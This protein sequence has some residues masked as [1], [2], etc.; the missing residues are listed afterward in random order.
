MY[1]SRIDKWGLQ[2]H[3]RA[4]Q[5][6]A[7][8]HQKAERDAVQKTS[9]MYI[10]DNKVDPKKLQ[11]YINRTS[12]QNKDRISTVANGGP[13][14]PSA[15]RLM[16]AVVACRTPS[17]VQSLEKRRPTAAHRGQRSNNGTDLDTEKPSD[18]RF[19]WLRTP[20]P[21]T[22]SSLLSVSDAQAR[23]E[24][25]MR[26]LRD[27]VNDNFDSGHWSDDL[28]ERGLMEVNQVINWANIFANALQFLDRGQTQQGFRLVQICFGQYKA[29]LSTGSMR[30]F[31]SIYPI[32]IRLQD[33]PDLR[34]RMIEYACKMSEVI[35]SEAHPF[36]VLWN[37]FF[38]MDHDEIISDWKPL[39]DCYS[40]FIAGHS[41]GDSELMFEAVM[42]RNA[43][44]RAQTLDGLVD[45]KVAEDLFQKDITTWE[46][47]T[48]PASPETVWLK[49]GLSSLYSYHQRYDDLNRI[50]TEIAPWTHASGLDILGSAA[51]DQ[52]NY[53]QA[54]ELYK[55]W[56][57]WSIDKFGVGHNETARA[58]FHLESLLRDIG[59]MDQA[60]VVGKQSE[61]SVDVLC[62]RIDELE[63]QKTCDEEGLDGNE[64][65][66]TSSSVNELNL[67]GDFLEF[68]GGHALGSVGEDSIGSELWTLLFD[69]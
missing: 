10:R 31:F 23:T 15:Q 35:H 2:K 18:F 32:L 11:T 69:S 3:F 25:C 16:A 28:D 34:K 48:H 61:I 43:N 7:L 49:R 36:T 60:D 19:P 21:Q 66:L 64:V 53:G 33:Y 26:C 39:I 41:N 4:K 5:V 46:N 62:M 44:I 29:L 17:P 1:K 47:Y 58:C 40:T 67:D 51:V 65:D 13:L 22:R 38:A 50:I 54:I 56:L 24:K 57:T 45:F 8:L 30:L 68:Q 37:Q 20:L 59:D 9:S 12:K 55:A 27:Y 42:A 14:S 52:G 63:I 6:Q